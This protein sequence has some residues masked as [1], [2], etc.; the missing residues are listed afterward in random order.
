MPSITDLQ[1]RAIDYARSGDFGPQALATNLELAK[2]SPTN[3]G[4]LTRLSRC[5]L[6][7]GQLDE[8]TAMLDAALQLNPQNTIA[9]SLQME[10]TKR[11]MARSGPAPSARQPRARSSSARPRAE[12]PVSLAIGGFGRTD[13]A[14]L[15]QRAPE[16]ALEALGPRIEAL[17]MALNDR[18]IAAKAVDVRNR[19][20]QSGARLFRRNTIQAVSG[21]LTAFHQG[22]RWEPQL[23]LGFHSSTAWGRD[24]VCAGIG[25]DF[26]PSADD[27]QE[28]GRERVLTHFAHFQQ[29]A[30]S[31]W[32]T[33]LSDWMSANGGFIQYG[34]Q[35][36]STDLLPK[37]AMK[38]LVECQQPLDLGW[39][40]Y[41]RW[42]FADRSA[43][44]D[45]LGDAKRLVTWIEVKYGDL[46]PL[47]GN[48]YR[49]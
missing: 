21:H 13:F 43:D 1:Q 3:E 41:G 40:F 11:R 15:G 34:D 14:A 27:P 20:G 45:I 32:R 12:K 2:L 25:F 38:W 17:L 18:P 49:G 19:A 48:L 26:S 35:A 23:H 9:R 47:W 36:P 42:L 7:G 29:I 37:D 4:A 22:G 30:S 39:I 24:A 16:A 6:E 28:R 8:A 44:A 33:F 31:A 5:Y 46:L 10:V